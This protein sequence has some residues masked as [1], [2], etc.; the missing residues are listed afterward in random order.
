MEL[1]PG[2]KQTEVGMIPEDWKTHTIGDSLRL[3][4]GRAFKPDD[5]K[6]FG[7]PIVRIQNLNDTDASFNYWP[8]P[9]EDRH[10][11]EAGDLLFA[12]SGTTGTSFGA[13]VWNGPIERCGCPY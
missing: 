7:L 9:V 10:R 12:W 13:R 2:Y 11:I 1:R 4:N 3:I 8:G 6:D 5:W